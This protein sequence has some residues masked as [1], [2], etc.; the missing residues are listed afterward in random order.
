MWQL[1]EGQAVSPSEPGPGTGPSA[2]DWPVSS[3][4]CSPA[5][6]GSYAQSAP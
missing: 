3:T 1:S 6:T 4:G 2:P 5:P